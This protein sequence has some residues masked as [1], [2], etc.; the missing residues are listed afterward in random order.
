MGILASQ[1]PA[2]AVEVNHDRQKP[3]SAFWTIDA[4]GHLSAGP[5][6][7]N[8]LFHISGWFRDLYGLRVFQQFARVGVRKLIQRLSSLCSEGIDKSLSR[9]FED[10][11]FRVGHTNLL[12]LMLWVL[13]NCRYVIFACCALVFRHRGL[14]ARGRW[15]DRSD[16]PVRRP[17]FFESVPRERTLR[18]LRIVLF[19][20][21]NF[22]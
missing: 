3:L 8:L 20:L 15:Q 16:G 5:N 4:Y 10:G 1:D 21:G 14:L 22:V 19:A 2:P 13:V 18:V 6:R 12:L 7:Q 11:F 17:G 9:R